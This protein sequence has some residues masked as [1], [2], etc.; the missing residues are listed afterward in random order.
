MKM[1]K[2][3]IVFMGTPKFAV[4]ALEALDQYHKVNLVITQPDKVNN[5]GKKIVFNPVKQYAIDNNI[6]IIQ[7]ENVNSDEVLSYLKSMDIDYIVVV[8]YG[9]I[10]KEEIRNIAKKNIVNIHAS[11][12]PK[13]RGA[14]PIQQSIMDREEETG[15]SIMKVD[16]GLDKGQVYLKEA[17]KISNKDF[18]TIHNELADLGARL[19]LDY[20]EKNESQE[21]IGQAQD[22]NLATYAKKIYKELGRLDFDNIHK[23]I[24]KIKGLSPKP[25]A[26]FSIENMDVKVI[27][28]EIHSE[29]CENSFECGQVL[30]VNDDGIFVNCNNGILKFTK[31]QFPGKKAMKVSDYLKGNTFEY[32]K[33][34]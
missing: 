27:D 1:N 20:I 10:I 9:Q 3:N 30:K 22:E 5:R 16:K 4:K 12:L 7:P 31:I 29:I 32:K 17:I 11:L 24:G 8:A 2:Q 6:D 33:L 25:G 18:I 21:I 34:R 26:F 13:Y 14:A 15:V 28:G 23:E 19:I